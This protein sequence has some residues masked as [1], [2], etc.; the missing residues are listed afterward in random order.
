MARRASASPSSASAPEG[1][2]EVTGLG[3]RLR[4]GFGLLGPRH[5]RHT[6][7]VEQVGALSLPV[8]D[9]GV[10]VGVNQQGRPAVLGINRP[11]PFDVVLIGGLW[12][13]QVLALRAAATGAR[14]AVE[15]ARGQAWMPLV[16]A[17]GGGQN[18][19]AVYDVGRVPPQGASAGTPVLV[20]RDCGMRPPRGRV[21]SA[22][23][24][25]V[26]TLLP[27]LS[28]VAPR[29]MRQARLVGVQR[30]SPDEATEIGRVIGLPRP[31]TRSLPGLQDGITLWCAE[32]DRQYVMTQATDAE[33]GLLGVARRM[34]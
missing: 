14:V 26:L 7:P 8:G 16:H 20:V 9:D 22:P 12:T 1:T 31:E 5:P 11:T 32:R 19:L 24:Q 6:L 27:Y 23:W 25:S 10:V 34:D 3:Q 21:T 15:T 18:G 2:P 30:V 33:T 28:P 29:L 13:A 17:M 4:T